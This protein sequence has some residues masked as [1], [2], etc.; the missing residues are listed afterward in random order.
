MTRDGLKKR[1][2]QRLAPFGLAVK[3]DDWLKLPD[4]YFLEAWNLV[5]QTCQLVVQECLKTAASGK[6]PNVKAD[7][8]YLKEVTKF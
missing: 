2:K 4:G 6:I 7:I 1:A 8:K 3:E 5:E